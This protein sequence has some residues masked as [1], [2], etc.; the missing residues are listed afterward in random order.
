MASPRATA[1]LSAQT[2]WSAEADLFVAAEFWKYRYPKRTSDTVIE[3]IVHLCLNS[4]GVIMLHVVAANMWAN[5]DALSS[6]TSES[7]LSH[8]H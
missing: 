8:V 5:K 7:V 1:G 6:L 2:N 3:F 4:L